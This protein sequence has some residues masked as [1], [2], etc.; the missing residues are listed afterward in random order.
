MYVHGWI[1]R[2]PNYIDRER[3]KMNTFVLDSEN[4]ITVYSAGDQ[5]TEADG[6]QRFKTVDELWQLAEGWPATRLVEIWNSIPGLPPVKKFTDR[7]TAIT[8][9]WKAIQS[10]D[11]GAGQQGADVAPE[12]S[13]P[14]KTGARS[15]KGTRAKV[16]AKAGKSE[17]KPKEA[18]TMREGSKSAKVLGLLRQ[19]KGAT[20]KELMKATGWQPHSVRGFLSGAVGKKMG[21]TVESSKRADGDRA[22]KIDR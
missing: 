15:K 11:G 13:S 2:Q 21:L 12:A 16:P 19:P 22:Y 7:A 17:R 18:G 5:P 8:R 9:I 10:L 4:G 3:I 1:K 6:A 14:G 20:L